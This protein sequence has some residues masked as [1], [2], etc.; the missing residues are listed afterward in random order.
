MKFPGSADSREE[1]KVPICTIPTFSPQVHQ[2]TLN[3][4]LRACFQGS[5]YRTSCDSLVIFLQLR[6]HFILPDISRVCA[7]LVQPATHD[8]AVC[9]SESEEG[10]GMV[11]GYI[12]L[13][14]LCFLSFQNSS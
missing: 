9:L 4:F 13:F 5:D 2:H 3:G 14:T 11:S 7:S 6:V 10:G 1:A 12:F 8:V